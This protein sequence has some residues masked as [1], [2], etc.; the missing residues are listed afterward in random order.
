[1]NNL[2]NTKI[3][4][5]LLFSCLVFCIIFFLE[6][7]FF[8]IKY[9]NIWVKEKQDFIRWTDFIETQIK[10][11][12]IFIDIILKQNFFRDNNFRDRWKWP[13]MKFINF[14][15]INNSWNIVFENIREELDEKIDINSINYWN[16]QHIDDFFF[17]RIN[18]NSVDYKDIIFIKKQEY[19]FED[20]L[21]DILFFT[22]INI[23]FSI[24][25]YLIWYIFVNKNLKPVEEILD[26]MGNFIHNASHEIKTPISII[27]SNLQIIKTTKLYEQDLIDNSINEIK[28]ID[29]LI[30]WLT[31]LSNITREKNIQEINV[32]TE[33]DNI[34]KEHIN[35]IK[36]KEIELKFDQKNQVLLNTNIQYFYIM[37][38]NLLRNAV[39]YNIINWKID[40]ILTNEKISISNTWIWIKKEEIDKIFDR[41][42]KCDSS[43]NSEWFGIGLSL[44]K[45][46]CSS[47]NRKIKVKSKENEITTF[48]VYF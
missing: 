28:R 3:K 6:I 16:M 46:I 25:F 40:I 43:R 14:I 22:I 24:F 8:T 26:D 35:L 4:L 15:L 13:W 36:E 7:V 30:S 1:M 33:I 38:S 48:E 39:K 47:F 10:D 42:Y 32:N 12:K 5:A 45:K 20:Y 41:F 31:E 21:E 2:K 19:D 11:D 23:I 44:V 34:I 17:K 27:S 18:I 37:F 29:E 9:L